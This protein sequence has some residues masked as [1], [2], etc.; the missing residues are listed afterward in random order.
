MQVNVILDAAEG[1]QRVTTTSLP[2]ERLQPLH[3]DARPRGVKSLMFT[4]Y[5]NYTAYP[6]RFD[7]Y[8]ADAPSPDFAGAPA[9]AA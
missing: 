9:R 2:G 4:E 3:I 6:H 8:I 5:E 1:E 7:G